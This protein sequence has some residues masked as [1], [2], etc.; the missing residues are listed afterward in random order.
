MKNV[1]DSCWQ[2]RYKRH[3]KSEKLKHSAEGNRSDVICWPKS[4]SKRCYY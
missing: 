2:K 1:S 3:G 4:L